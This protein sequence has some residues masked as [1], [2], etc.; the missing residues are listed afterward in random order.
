[1]VFLDDSPGRLAALGEILGKA[2]INIEGLFAAPA[3]GDAAFH[4]L[5]EDASAA[6]RTLEAAKF[7]VHE[8]RDVLILQ[9]EDR[10]GELGR[11]CRKLADVSVNINLIYV[12]TNTRLVVGVDNL[13]K[14]RA[15]L[16]TM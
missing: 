4:I 6:R 1:L 15:A 11:L 3:G 10:P 13:E 9:V 16:E 7:H 12:A 5:V 14:A 2:G 8:E